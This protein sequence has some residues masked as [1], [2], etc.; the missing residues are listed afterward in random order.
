VSYFNL[1]NSP[2]KI[3][4][5]SP[6]NI[7]TKIISSEFVKVEIVE[8]KYKLQNLI[9][10]HGTN[11]FRYYSASFVVYISRPSLVGHLITWSIIF[12]FSRVIQYENLTFTLHISKRNY[13]LAH[14][15]LHNTYIGERNQRKKKR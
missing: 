10:E 15:F 13:L 6:Q 4:I 12:L 3:K 14:F 1:K 9:E 7:C 5:V 11:N 2:T 8:K